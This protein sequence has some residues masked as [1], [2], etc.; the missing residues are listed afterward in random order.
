M[1]KLRDFELSEE[2]REHVTLGIYR[3]PHLFTL[4]NFQG[5][6]DLSGI[7]WTVDYPED[8]DFVK[9]VFT[10]FEGRELYFTFEDTLLFLANN[11]HVKSAISGNR[12][13]E[14]LS[15]FKIGK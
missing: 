3:R 10:E 12:R 15:S 4:E 14:K 1:R 11:P 5:N 6:E 9:L 7:R 2:E 8:L 13:N